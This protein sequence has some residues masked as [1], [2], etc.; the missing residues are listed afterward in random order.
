MVVE[1]YYVPREEFY[2]LSLK[3]LE[4]E[5]KEDLHGFHART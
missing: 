1:V 5:I 2:K 4:L 3:Q